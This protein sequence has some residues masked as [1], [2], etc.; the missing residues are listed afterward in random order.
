MVGINALVVMGPLLLGVGLVVFALYLYI[1]YGFLS[2]EN[3]LD[4]IYYRLPTK[5]ISK[6]IWVFYFVI[7][8]IAARYCYANVMFWLN[9]HLFHKLTLAS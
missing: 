1:R 8:S 4:Q 5:G 7:Y 9:L 2:V 3:L 6:S